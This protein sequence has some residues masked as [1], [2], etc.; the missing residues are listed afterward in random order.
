ME[1][2]TLTTEDLDGYLHV[3]GRALNEDPTFF[4][5]SAAD[6]D[7]LNRAAAFQ[8][9]AQSI[10]YN[11]HFGAFVDGQQIGLTSLLYVQQRE[12]VRHRMQL[13]QVYVAQEMRGRGIA[14]A[15]LHTA[16]AHARTLPEAEE[17]YLAVTVGNEAARQLYVQSGFK[18]AYIDRG[19]LKVDEAYYDLEWMGLRLRP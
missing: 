12:K 14:K 19:Y 5:A 1:I 7:M 15:L 10:P 16:I 3:W 4:A 13:H 18:T 17:I 11:P 2:R 8:R 9:L 6:P